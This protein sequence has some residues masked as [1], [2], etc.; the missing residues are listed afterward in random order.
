MRKSNVF[1]NKIF[2][3]KIL[4]TDMYLP[5]ALGSQC[6]YA[7]A[8]TL[9]LSGHWGPQHSGCT[10]IWEEGLPFAIWSLHHP[11]QLSPEEGQWPWVLALSW[12]LLAGWSPGWIE[13]HLLVGTGSPLGNRV[14]T[15]VQNESSCQQEANI[16]MGLVRAI[17]STMHN[18]LMLTLIN[19]KPTLT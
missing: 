17:K 6:I 1:A 15:T 16:E 8:N 9:C 13:T 14:L 18:L 7:F 11:Q 5:V 3:R 2:T 12:L 10:Q 4:L 19:R